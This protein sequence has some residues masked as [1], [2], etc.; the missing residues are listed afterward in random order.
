MHDAVFENQ[1][2]LSPEF[3]VDLAARLQPGSDELAAA[4]DEQRYLDRISRDVEGGERAGAHATPTV[5]INGQPYLGR[6]QFD[7]LAQVMEAA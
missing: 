3:L 7:D 4:I 2:R 6:S 1:R 5:F